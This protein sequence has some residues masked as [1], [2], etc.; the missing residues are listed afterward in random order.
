MAMKL[1]VFVLAGLL[2]ATSLAHADD[3]PGQRADRRQRMLERF[4]TNRDGRLDRRERRQAKRMRRQMKIQRL[5]RKFDKNGDGNLG[6]GELPPRLA[7]RLRRFDRNGDGWIDARDT[8][9]SRAAPRS[10]AQIDQRDQMQPR[11][12]RGQQ[13]RLAPGAQAAPMA[14]DEE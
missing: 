12:R 2:G 9:V 14:P 11:G 3:Q 7:D 1:I 4:D 10:G 6:P 13:Q 5:I 8:N